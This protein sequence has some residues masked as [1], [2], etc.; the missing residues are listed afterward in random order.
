MHGKWLAGVCLWAACGGGPEHAKSVSPTGSA[1]GASREGSKPVAGTI[2]PVADL[3]PVTPPPVYPRDGELRLNQL[4]IK[5]SHNS[6]HLPPAVPATDEAYTMP[7]LTAQFT[8]YGVRA[9]ELDLH[10]DQGEFFVYHLAVEDPESTCPRLAACL[11][12]INAW[13]AANPGHAPLVVYLDPRDET[14]AVKVGD[15]LHELEA[16]LLAGLPRAQVVIPDDV[17]GPSADL[18][19]AIEARGW[20]TLGALRGKVLFVYWSF[21]DTA[22]RYADNGTSLA[23][24]VMFVA[25]TAPGWRHAMILGMDTAQDQ[26]AQIRAAVLQGY[27]VRTRADDEPGRGGDFPARRDAALRSGAQA[28]LTDYPQG[29]GDYRVDIPGGTPGRCNPVVGVVD[30]CTSGDVEH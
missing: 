22:W 10:Y 23:G 4:Q 9:V 1:G 16:V 25:A 29:L 6:Y 15:H 8:T 27:L 21:S 11:S 20:P 17:I 26:E 14:D 2:D 24:R 12:E 28:V 7:T 3:P 18:Q 13:S 30:G 5:G 19:A